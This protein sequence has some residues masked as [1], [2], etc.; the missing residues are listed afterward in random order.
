MPEYEFNIKA[1]PPL[2]G[3]YHNRMADTPNES[4]DYHFGIGGMI[5]QEFSVE[6]GRL[7]LTATTRGV[8]DTV[9]IKFEFEDSMATSE[10]NSEMSLTAFL[11]EEP[12]EI[13]K[14]I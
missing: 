13:L 14:R 8:V 11:R 12:E 1:E 9:A 10:I 5:S 2:K 3:I 6:N 4:G 7:V